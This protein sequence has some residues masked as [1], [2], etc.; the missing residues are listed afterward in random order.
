MLRESVNNSSYG[1]DASFE[2]PSDDDEGNDDDGY[3]DSDG[4][5]SASDDDDEG[6]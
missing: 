2:V 6:V 5:E 3:G 1:N 4:F